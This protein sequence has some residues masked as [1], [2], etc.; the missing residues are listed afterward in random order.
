MW[1]LLCAGSLSY[2]LCGPDYLLGKT[3]FLSPPPPP[4]VPPDWPFPRQEPKS[5]FSFLLPRGPGHPFSPESSKPGE[6]PDHAGTSEPTPTCPPQPGR[7]GTAVSIVRATGLPTPKTDP[8]E[9]MFEVCL[10]GQVIPRGRCRRVFTYSSGQLCGSL[11]P[12]KMGLEAQR[13]CQLG[14]GHSFGSSRVGI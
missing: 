10:P 13:A 14:Q 2:F 12:F 5:H 9:S 6:A 7:P 1:L 11:F 3:D 4:A 8:S